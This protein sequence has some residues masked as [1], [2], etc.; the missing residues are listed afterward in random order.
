MSIRQTPTDPFELWIAGI[1]AV[2][3]QNVTIP[4][5]SLTI[6]LGSAGSGS[7]HADFDHRQCPVCETQMRLA[8][9]E[10]LRLDRD[11]GFERHVYRCDGCANVS[12][13]VFETPSK[14]VG[15][16]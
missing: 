11:D 15:A 13:F 9:I 6:E 4:K 12:R 10:P 8:S 5:S 1:K 14:A 7:M 16:K 2:W 3:P